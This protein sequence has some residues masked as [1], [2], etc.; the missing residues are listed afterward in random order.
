MNLNF[1]N[2]FQC[3]THSILLSVLV[4]AL[5]TGSTAIAKARIVKIKTAAD[6][7][8]AGYESFRAM[9]GD[10]STMWHT[11]FGAGDPKPPHVIILDLGDVYEISGFI[12]LPRMGGDNGTIKDYE[13]YVSNDKKKFGA[14]IIKGAFAKR[15]GENIIKFQ[16]PAKGRYI[17]LRALS[18]VNNNPWTSIAEL[19]IL[20]E[21]I[22]FVSTDSAGLMIE[23]PETETELQYE[24]LRRDIQRRVHIL[25]HAGQTFHRQSLILESDHDPLDVVLRRTK[26]LIEDFKQMSDAPDLSKYENQLKDLQAKSSTVGLEEIE[27]RYELFEKAY[28]LRRKIAFSNPLLNFDK[29]LFTKR[30]RPTFNHMCD[31]YYGINALP[32]GGLYILS[33]PFGENPKVKDILDDSV[34]EKGRLKGQKLTDGSFVSPDL[35]YD[36]KTIMFAYVECKGDKVHRHHTDPS[37][38]HWHE[39]RSYHILKVNIDGTGLKQLTDGTWNDFDPCWL[40]NG[41]VVFISERRGGY[42]RCGRV[43][44]TYTLFDMNPD[45]TDIRCLSP[46]ETNEWHPSITNDGMII[47]TRWDYIDRHGCTAHL[48][49]ITTPDGRDSRA[50]HGNFAPRELRADME[51]DVRAIPGSN[52]FVATGAPHHGQAFGS[53]LVFDPRI[54]DDDAMAPVK[55]ITPEVDFPETQGGAQVYGTAWP[56]SEKYYLCV[57]DPTMQPGIGSQGKNPLRG[58]YGIYLVDIFGNKELIYRDPEIACQSPMPLHPRFKPPVLPDKSVR[59]ARG[60]SAEATLALI[61]VYDTLTPWPQ[62]MKIKSLRVYQLLPMSVPSGAP[63]HETSLREPTAGDSVVLTRYVLGTVPVEEDGSAHFSVPARKELFFQALDE[64]GLAVQSMRSAT[65]LQ[66]GEMLVCQGCHEPR[67]RAPESLKNIPIAMRREPSNLKPDVDGTNPFSYP[68]LVQPVLDKHCVQCHENHPN[69]APRLDREVVV[70]GKQ[71]WYASYHSLAPEYSFWQYGHRHRTIPGKFGAR[72]SKLYKMLQKGHHD[73][74]LSQEE[75]HRITV[76]LDSCSIFYGVYE[77]EGGIAQL[78]GKIVYPTLE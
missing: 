18:E 44:P 15:N 14:P 17:K 49:W 7:E 64:K 43:C 21:G 3:K 75:M 1:K 33:D 4:L 27:A 74:K 37:K 57:Y 58:R 53:L 40:P 2:I 67:H 29:I 19:T 20:T 11:F 12:Y 36:A 22:H 54:K 45:G 69:K 23:A 13:F 52:K 72:V 26:A 59:V 35:S 73:V 31:Q 71:K 63:P 30:H 62:D 51:L 56:L 16:K 47:Y 48:P 38:G 66:P 28:Q 25:R 5:F 6:S 50:V 68:R 10:P 76:W 60:Q 78:E 39:G 42:L 55:R 70:K 9:D 65:Y 34:V 8:K 24:I 32:G 61:N 46:H 41:R 77:K